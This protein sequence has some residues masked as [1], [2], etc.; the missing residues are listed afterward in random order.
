MGC[1]M[2]SDPLQ[3]RIEK[4]LGPFKVD[5]AFEVKPGL[6]VLFGPSGCG[7]S[8]VLNC[9]AGLLAPDKGSI[10]VAG[11][12]FFDDAA[13]IN[14]PPQARHVGY[15]FQNPSLFPHLTVAENICFGIDRWDK[16]KQ[17]AR[18]AH[19]LELL[20]LQGLEN[21]KV[22]QLSGGQIQR[23][24]LARALAPEPKL[25]LLDEPFSALD[26]RLRK[27]LAAELQSM[28][29]QLQLPMVLVTHSRSEALQVA[30]TVV[31]IDE[32]KVVGVGDPQRLLNDFAG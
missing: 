11:T 18:G 21:R 25:I 20:K 26:D 7:K 14:L 24:A 28:Q 30:D 31:L 8:T 27:Q 17:Q 23:V 16:E 2:V 5:V 6:T 1:E 4:T 32:G 19:L 22:T 15:V 29:K 9:L 12:K 13:A 3:V 10:T